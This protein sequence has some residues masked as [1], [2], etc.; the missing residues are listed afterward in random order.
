MILTLMEFY[1]D[2]SK[3]LN[4]DLS[5]NAL[6]NG[7]FDNHFKWK[8]S[9]IHKAMAWME[10]SKYLEP[11]LSFSFDKLASKFHTHNVSS[12]KI[13]SPISQIPPLPLK[14]A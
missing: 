11:H 9:K 4:Q 1:E 8:I 13:L 14:V 5:E 6:S 2:K 7:I 10:E 3:K 12:E